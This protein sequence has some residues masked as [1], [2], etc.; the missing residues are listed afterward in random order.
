[1]YYS[2]LHGEKDSGIW[3]IGRRDKREVEIV[4]LEELIALWH[5]SPSSD[6]KRLL[7]VSDSCH[8]GA[9]VNKLEKARSI[10][11]ISTV[12]SCKADETCTDTVKGGDFTR[13]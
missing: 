4:S 3:A 6:Y 10:V 1:M 12:A 2:G 9:W 11:N 8:S 5:T 7:I 13:Y